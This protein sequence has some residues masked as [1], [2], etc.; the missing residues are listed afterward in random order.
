MIFSKNRIVWLTGQP[1]SGKSKLAKLLYDKYSKSNPC[2]IIDGDDLR[3]KTG[4]FDYSKEGRDKNI[5][6]AQLLA[7]FLYH[8]GYVVIVALVSPYK[9]L[10]EQFKK[11]FGDNIYEVYVHCNDL[12][13]KE[14]YHVANYEQPTMNYL[15]LNTT[16]ENPNQSAKKIIS[17]IDNRQQE[18]NM[19]GWL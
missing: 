18:T 11:E 4:N 1:G 3:Q 13:G 12:R 7:R 5:N 8:S 16:T 6:N 19:I 2:I 17:Y 15:D 9:D 10:R 14:E